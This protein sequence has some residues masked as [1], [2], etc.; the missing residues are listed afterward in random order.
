MSWR[1]DAQPCGPLWCLPGT[2]GALAWLRA[3]DLPAGARLGLGLGP[4]PRAAEL[5][6]AALLGGICVVPFN[7]RLDAA[8]LAGQAARAGLAAVVAEAGHP[9]AAARPDARPLPA[10]WPD[11][12]PP[13][14]AL[15]DGEAEALVLF[16]SGTTG[17]A[18]AVRLPRRALA[19]ALAAS[20][21]HLGLGRADTWYGCLPLDHI[22]GIGTVLRQLVAGYR[23]VLAPRFDAAGASADLTAHGITAASLVPTQLHR[24]LAVRGGTPW[25]A[26]LR[27]LLVG[28]AACDDDLAAACTAHGLAPCRTWGLSE[29]CA[30]A[31]AQR[32]GRDDRHAGPPLPGMAVR[33]EDG[34]GHPLPAG[35][36]GVLALR[37]PGLFLGY[38]QGGGTDAD[39]WFRTGDRGAVHADG[40]VQVLGRRDEVIVCGG[41]KI[42]PGTVEARLL[43]H[44]AVAEAAVGALADA[45]WGAVPAALLVARGAPP[46]DAALRAWLDAHLPGPWRPRR[47]RWVAAL[48]RTPLGKLRRSAVAGLLASSA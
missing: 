37:G 34:E 18:K 38:D 15:P 7:R 33:A 36:I 41:E 46:A 22:A 8:A 44:P 48:P 35:A 47:W 5:L 1:L 32:P 31:A 14:T 24:L 20:C 40:C 26:T 42:D 45:E 11:P 23:L 10:A 2:A 17:A 39:G 9:L 19:H 13:P 21:A 29:A 3:L 25:P 12:I 28:G 16:T 6:Q 4:S 30:M 27:L 43:R